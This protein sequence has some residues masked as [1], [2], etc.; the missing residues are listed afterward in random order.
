MGY[1]HIAGFVPTMAVQLQSPIGLVTVVPPIDYMSLVDFG[2]TQYLKHAG[3][4]ETKL[5]YDVHGS[6]A[7]GPYDLVFDGDDAVLLG[8]TGH[9]ICAS[10]Q[11]HRN[12]I[13]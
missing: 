1:T 2:S 4:S 9:S 7:G 12:V 8:Q 10:N 11:C 5:V 6:V 13:G 3:T